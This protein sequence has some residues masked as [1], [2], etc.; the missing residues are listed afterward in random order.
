[1]RI[2]FIGLGSQGSG[3]AEMIAKSGHEL[4]VWARRPGVVDPYV[5]LGARAAASPADLARDCD[6]V[7]T[8]VMADKDVVELAEERGVLAAMRPGSVFVNHATIAPETVRRLGERAAA[9]GVVVDAPV[10]GS[11][12]AIGRRS[13]RGE[14]RQF[15]SDWKA[16]LKPRSGPEAPS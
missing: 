4:T 1:M 7:A 5:A 14:R 15:H 9:E 13:P 11:S 12:A 8:C 6:I 2:G 10:S 16:G 3:M